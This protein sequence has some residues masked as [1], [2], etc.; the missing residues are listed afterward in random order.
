M[1]EN[2]KNVLICEK[3]PLTFFYFSQKNDGAILI[4]IISRENNFDENIKKKIN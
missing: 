2:A 3:L 4:V 1:Y